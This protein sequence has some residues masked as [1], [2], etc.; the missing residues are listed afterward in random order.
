MKQPVVELSDCILCEV[1]REVCPSV[2]RLNDA[3]YIEV[4]DLAVYPEA[5]VNEAIANCPAGCIAWM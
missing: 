1:C 4:A 3:G 5:G 2:F